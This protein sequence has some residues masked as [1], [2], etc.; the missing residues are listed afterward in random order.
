MKRRTFIKA[1]TL[2]AFSVSAFGA[3]H[4]NGKHFTGNNPTTTD[5]L[6]PFYRPGAP[7]R[8]NLV[9]AGS[10]GVPLN[11]VGTVYQPDG[12]TPHSDVLIEAWQCDEN[13]HYDNTSDDYLFRG[14]TKTDDNGK[15]NFQTIVP[16]P[17][18]A[19]PNSW[20]PAHIHL[21]ISSA[22]YQDLI[23]QIYFKGDPHLD[24]DSSSSSPTAANRILKISEK[25]GVKTVAFDVVMSKNIPLD[26][27]VYDKISGL[28]EMDKGMAEFYREDDLL[29][30]KRN[31]QISE[32]LIYKGN[33]TFEGAMGWRKVKFD[34]LGNGEIKAE[35]SQGTRTLEG[36][37]ILKYG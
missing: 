4:C 8:S 14:I 36:K 27:T 5:I 33:N 20:R 31:G 3:I 37:K 29:M 13:E 2:T 23:T 22:S 17:Y 15:Y 1:S 6:G 18:E 16:V 10:K 26:D 28:Y 25:N 7:M 24:S 21:R 11:L 9:P 35:L 34:L 12:T 32:G 19:S 30:M